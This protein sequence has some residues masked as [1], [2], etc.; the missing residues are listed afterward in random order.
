VSDDP[1]R[2]VTEPSSEDKDRVIA[3]LYGVD[4]T[5]SDFRS[6][7]LDKLRIEFERTPNPMLPWNALQWARDRG[8]DIP[9]W[10]VDYLRDKAVVLEKIIDKD[11]GEEEAQEVG[12]ALGFGAEGKGKTTAG[13]KLRQRRRDFTTAVHIADLRMQDV[14]KENAVT[15]TATALSVSSATAYIAHKGYGGTATRFVATLMKWPFRKSGNQ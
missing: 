5:A 10:V 7:V 15:E 3:A 14:G 4:P 11:V 8:L 2:S 12:R 6:Q 1:L 9:G 13:A